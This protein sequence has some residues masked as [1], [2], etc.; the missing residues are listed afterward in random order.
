MLAGYSTDNSH[1]LLADEI[2]DLTIQNVGHELLFPNQI[3]F[4]LTGISNVEIVETIL[5]YKI[6]QT[7]TWQY[8]YPE[9]SGTKKIKATGT[10]V[11]SGNSYLPSG[12]TFEY[13]FQLHNTNGDYF[14]TEMF[15]FDYLN[16][17]HKWSKASKG[18]LSIYSHGIPSQL[19]DNL[20]HDA[21]AQFPSIASLAGITKIKP[22]TA[23]I[24]NNPREASQT[25]PVISKT[26]IRDKLYGGF[27]FQDYD[28]FIIGGAD[29]NVLIHESAHLIIGQATESPTARIPAWLNEGLAMYFELPLDERDLTAR[30]ARTQGIL[31]PLENMYSIPGKTSDV[32]LF[33]AQSK[34]VVKFIIARYGSEKMTQ[35]LGKLKEGEPVNDATHKVYGMSLEQLDKDWRNSIR[36]EI[37]RTLTIDPGTFWTSFILAIAFLISVTYVGINWL[38]NRNVKYQEQQYEE[39]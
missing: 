30:I 35:F 20:L 15:Q 21:N 16:P 19:I 3:K 2:D 29:L 31:R 36:P 26:S 6:S 5:F 8:I 1:V 11:T 18:P 27:A 10:I 22:F 39:E 7:G 23:V 13:Y 37:R 17:E 28:V 32:R 38:K 9:I 4:T 12:V 34:S 24:V 33:Y 14:E 25:F